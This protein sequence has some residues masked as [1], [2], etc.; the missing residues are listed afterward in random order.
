MLNRF[1]RGDKVEPTKIYMF[2]IK[3]ASGQTEIPP[4]MVG[5]YVLA[6]TTAEDPNKAAERAVN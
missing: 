4:P 5:A 1:R 2:T 6:Y 3:I